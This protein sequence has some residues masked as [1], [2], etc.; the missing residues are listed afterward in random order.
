[1]VVLVSISPIVD[2]RFALD[3]LSP[4]VELGSG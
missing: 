4:I 1:M 2:I 3:C